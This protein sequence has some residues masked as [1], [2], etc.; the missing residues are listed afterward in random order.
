MNHKRKRARNSRAGCKLCKF[1]KVN[2]YAAEHVH[3][4]LDHLAGTWSAEE[5]REF[6]DRIKAFGQVDEGLWGVNGDSPHTRN[7]EPTGGI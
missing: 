4:E 5:A 7:F 2:G 1:W 6:T 3:T